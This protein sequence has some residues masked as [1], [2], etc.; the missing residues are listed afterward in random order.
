MN[1]VKGHVSRWG[2]R[3]RE[4]AEEVQVVN[5]IELNLDLACYLDNPVPVLSFGLDIYWL[6]PTFCYPAQPGP[7]LVMET[8][9]WAKLKTFFYI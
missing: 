4:T 7:G 5:C 9:I 2:E 6:K 1:S 8:Q 3:T